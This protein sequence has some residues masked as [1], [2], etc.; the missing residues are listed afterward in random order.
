MTGIMEFGY[1][2]NLLFSVFD[3]VVS[4]N[5]ESAEDQFRKDVRSNE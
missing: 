1:A 5:A 2:L 4:P 3:C